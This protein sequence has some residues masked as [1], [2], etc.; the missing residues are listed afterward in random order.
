MQLDKEIA[1]LG[2]SVYEQI[3][4]IESSID[5]DYELLQK[6]DQQLKSMELY[7]VFNYLNFLP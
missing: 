7:V 6:L 1:T 5:S 2:K 3:C 4:T